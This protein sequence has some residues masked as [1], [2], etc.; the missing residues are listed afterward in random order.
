MF[1]KKVSKESQILQDT[2]IWI[3]CTGWVTQVV[4]DMHSIQGQVTNN[5]TGLDQVCM[6][7]TTCVA[8]YL[9]YISKVSSSTLL[10]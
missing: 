7:K 2:A 10:I 5:I 3:I 8:M 6:L 1:I 4:I 9:R